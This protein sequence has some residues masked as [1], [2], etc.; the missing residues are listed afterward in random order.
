M[1]IRL[2]HSV[3]IHRSRAPNRVWITPPTSPDL[4]PGTYRGADPVTFSPAFPG[5]ESPFF[6]NDRIIDNEVFGDH[7][8]TLYPR[9]FKGPDF[10]QHTTNLSN[11]TE[12]RISSFSERLPTERKFKEASSFKDPVRRMTQGFV[13]K[14]RIN[15]LYPRFYKP[16]K[17][18]T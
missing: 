9:H 18:K 17:T 1:A 7:Y 3:I 6:L 12:L 2:S 5:K 13:T 11:A 10:R 16:P 4:G 15:K 8:Q 14:E